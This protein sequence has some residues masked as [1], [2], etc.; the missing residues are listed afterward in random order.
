MTRLNALVRLSVLLHLEYIHV[1]V[2]WLCGSKL[3]DVLRAPESWVLT[4]VAVTTTP[5][6]RLYSHVFQQSP[7]LWLVRFDIHQCPSGPWHE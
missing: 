2:V 5:S 6:G 3:R 4:R 7:Y 1:V